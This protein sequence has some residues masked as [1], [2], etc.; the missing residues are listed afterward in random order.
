MSWLE[1]YGYDA[2]LDE[3]AAKSERY[4]EAKDKTQTELIKFF[5]LHSNHINSILMHQKNKE[6]IDLTKNIMELGLKD[7]LSEKQKDILCNFYAHNS[8]VI[9]SEDYC[10][11]CSDLNSYNKSNFIFS[12]KDNKLD[13]IEKIEKGTK[14][15]KIKYINNNIE[16]NDSFYS[17]IQSICSYKDEWSEKQSYVINKWILNHAYSNRLKV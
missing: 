7:I 16:E 17:L 14:S 15:M 1:D 11:I 5:Y 4:Y 12:L 13:F 6:Y 9:C 2:I 10:R 8:F 3:Q